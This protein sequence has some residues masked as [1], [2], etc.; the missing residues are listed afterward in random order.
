MKAAFEQLTTGNHSFLIR[1]FEEKSFSAPYH[2][3]PEYELTFI[4]NGSGKRYVGSHMQDYFPG[5]L[6]LLG[7]NL[8]HCWKTG[9]S[10]GEKSES[11]VIQFREDCMGEDF[12][13]K[14]ELNGIRN[15]LYKSHNGIYFNQD[16]NKTAEKMNAVLK[17]KNACKKFIYFLDL[18]HELTLIK[19]YALLTKENYYEELS[20]NEKERINKVMAFIVENFREEISLN[21]AAALINMTPHAFCKYFKKITRKTFI[22]A[23]NDYRVDFASKQL[24]HTNNSISEIGFGSGFNDIS[25]FHR[26]FKQRTKL[27]PLGYRKAFVKKII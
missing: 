18:L 17:E 21:E 23:V 4:A 12:F 2:F 25:N 7:S 15:V 16:K 27:S 6:V 14:P 11:I 19:D 1:R 3:H 13:N 8:P 10:S 22:E 20:L 26:T 5:D 9:D 24:I